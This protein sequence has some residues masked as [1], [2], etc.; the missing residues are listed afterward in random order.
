[1]SP[2]AS[3]SSG[4]APYCSRCGESIPPAANYCPGCGAERPT[5][6]THAADT[7][8]E[9]GGITDWAI[10]FVPGSTLRNVL[11]GIVYGVFYF[12][13][14]PLLVYAYW[15]RGGRYR[16]RTYGV[17]GALAIGLIAIAVVGAVVGP[18]PGEGADTSGVG[19][20][21]PTATPAQAS[22]FGVRISYSGS[23]QGAL[24]VTSGGSSQTKSISGSGTET[25]GIDGDVAIVSVNAQKADDSGAEITVQILRGGTVV[26]ESSTSS[27][28]GVARVA[29][30]F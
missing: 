13:G 19:E 21:T 15:R 5:T 3:G 25:I 9:A 28:Y 17:I 30:S 20:P 12:V 1:M 26:A 16:R 14:I 4:D 29:E 8:A 7:D 23:W 24:S 18:A 2:E 11:V 27:A 6:A 10:G 22:E